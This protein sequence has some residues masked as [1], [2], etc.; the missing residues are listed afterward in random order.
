MSK[1][2]R[3]LL[4]A[5]LVAVPA[6]AAVPAPPAVN[7]EDRAAIIDDIAA[8]LDE[9]YV[10]PETA[11]RMEE[12]VRRQQKSGAYDRLGTLDAF[13]Q[14]LTEDFQSVS[15]DLHL[16]V[17]WSPEPPAAESGGPTPEQQR[18]RMSAQMRRDNYCFRKVERLAGN[19]GYLK[20]DCFAPAELG[21]GVAV[22]AMGFLSG[23]D[24]L[25]F[26]LRDNGGGNPTMIQLL[27]SY[28]LPEEPT[29]LNSFYIRRG[30][31]TEQFWTHAWVPGTRLPDVPVFVLTSG[32]TF[33]GAEEFSYNLK[34]LKR[35]TLVGETTGGGAHP[36]QL[37]SVKG[38]PVAVSLPFGR[39][40]NPI[41]G[42]NWEGTGVEPDVKVPAPEA[43]AVAH[44]RALAKIAEQAADPERKAEVDFVRGVIEDR[45]KPVE[46]PSGEL[47]A[48]AG[49]YGPRS[50]FL[51]D[52]AL[53]YQ[54][55]RGRKLKLLPVGQ[56]RFLVGDLDDFRLRFERDAGGK[57]VRLVGL[58]ADG[59]EEPHV[60]EEG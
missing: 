51:E 23:S 25:I 46:L 36:I 55:G 33:S 20:L 1:S 21:G 3:I 18:A 6:L 35:A 39:A 22:A 45:A 41:S 52:G 38:Y 57:V 31:R 10:F 29:H 19:V 24:A 12:H 47:Q 48:F 50:I 54:R 9:I 8:A 13:T 32:R 16:R 11:K 56:D 49:A 15:H 42:T 44:S 17:N 40:V 7:A 43:L 30:D 27:T 34:N 28:L 60:R 14:K 4:L 5:L 26:D 37:H 53:W 2:L 59:S 58:Y